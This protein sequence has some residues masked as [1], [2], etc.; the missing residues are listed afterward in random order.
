[1]SL[2]YYLVKGGNAALQTRIEAATDMELDSAQLQKMSGRLSHET[3]RQLQMTWFPNLMQ[4][5]PAFRA[6]NPI[7]PAVKER[8]QSETPT[9][10]H[11]WCRDDEVFGLSYRPLGH[12]SRFVE[13]W[14]STLTKSERSTYSGDVR[15]LLA[16]FTSR[17][18][19]GMC[20]SCH[21]ADEQPDNWPPVIQWAAKRSERDQHRFTRFSHDPHLIV[22]RLK[23]CSSCH[24]LDS[25]AD[26]METYSRG[27]PTEFESNFL[28]LE[29]ETCADCHTPLAAGDQCTTCH[30]YHVDTW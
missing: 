28:P 29:R 3:M 16:A 22:P 17:S 27:D 14:L 11:G 7:P 10:T 19:H 20:T 24:Q 5:V 6:G 2:L 15:M 23:D 18:S 21:S 13:T 9:V 1:M 12:A 26:S 4:E 8:I 25:T 30:L